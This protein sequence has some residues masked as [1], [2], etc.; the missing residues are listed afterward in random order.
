MILSEKNERIIA[1][2]KHDLLR[3]NF[4][5]LAQA[6]HLLGLSFRHPTNSYITCPHETCKAAVK[7]LELTKI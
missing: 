6:M 2:S 7:T 5:Q 3:A 1:K 4:I